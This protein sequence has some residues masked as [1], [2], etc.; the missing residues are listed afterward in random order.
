MRTINYTPGQ[1]IKSHDFPGIDRKQCFIEGEIL[2]VD[3]TGGWLEV[4]VTF[5]S[6]EVEGNTRVG[7]T[8]TV[9]IQ[10][11]LDRFWEYERIEIIK[12]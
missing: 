7:T 4:N 6:L 9:P 1:H 5:D 11:E 10:T 2:S 8:V 12:N 3:N